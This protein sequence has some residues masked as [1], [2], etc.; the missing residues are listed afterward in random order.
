MSEAGI[1]QPW[2]EKNPRPVTPTGN[3]PRRARH[4]L[5]DPLNFNREPKSR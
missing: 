1:D 4:T 5:T 2:W 3:A